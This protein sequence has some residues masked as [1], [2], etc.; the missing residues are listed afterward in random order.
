MRTVAS[1]GNTLAAAVSD[2]RQD[3][4]TATAANADDSAGNQMR[5]VYVAKAAESA[6]VLDDDDL[7]VLEQCERVADILAELDSAI[8][9][10]GVSIVSASGATK[11]NPAVIESRQQRIALT[12]LMA[13]MDQR[14]AA[15]KAGTNATPG[16]QS[17]V[18]GVYTGTGAQ[19]QQRDAE[20]RVRG[21]KGGQ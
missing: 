1:Q 14:I 16:G 13:V 17:G 9:T 18:R 5:A 15:A 19:N 2:D 11:I 10:H 12:R 20:R 7:L 8:S 4:M 21:Q 3:T 6:L